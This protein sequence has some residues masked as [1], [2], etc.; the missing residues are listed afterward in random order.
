MKNLTLSD[1][2]S[3]TIHFSLFED[4]TPQFFKGEE[5]L[6]AAV[7]PVTMMAVADVNLFGRVVWMG[8]GNQISKWHR[9]ATHFFVET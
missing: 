9:S 7:L 2:C 5:R 1:R 6:K 8:G 4:R 3:A